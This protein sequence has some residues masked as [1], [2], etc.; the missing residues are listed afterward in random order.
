MR[1]QMFDKAYKWRETTT[2]TVGMEEGHE[3]G[4]LM[5]GTAVSEG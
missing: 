4:G 1:C 5:V 2:R 3:V